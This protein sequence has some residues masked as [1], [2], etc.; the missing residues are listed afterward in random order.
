MRQGAGRIRA[1][2]IT[3][4][5]VFESVDGA[6]NNQVDDA[7]RAKCGAS[8]YLAAMIGTRACAISEGA[9]DVR[10]PMS[11]VGESVPR[12]ERVA[13]IVQCGPSL[14]KQLRECDL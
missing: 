2:G 10:E 14:R 12:D 11:D 7:Y 6:I 8:P 1:A 3:K 4:E 5:V 13:D 9:S